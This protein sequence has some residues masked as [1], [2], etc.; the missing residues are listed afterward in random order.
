MRPPLVQNTI[1]HFMLANP[2]PNHR[3]ILPSTQNPITSVNSSR[4]NLIFSVNELEAETGVTWIGLPQ[5]I[6]FISSALNVRW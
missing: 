2:E 3:I 5:D 4:V 1:I 6:S